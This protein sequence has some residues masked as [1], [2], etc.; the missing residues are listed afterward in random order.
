MNKK[1]GFAITIMVLLI[2]L[3]YSSKAYSQNKAVQESSDGTISVNGNKISAQDYDLTPIPDQYNTGCI[4]ELIE[5]SV[6]GKTVDGIVSYKTT[7]D[8]KLILDLIYGN[9]DLPDNAIIANRDFPLNSYAIYHA[10]KL[11]QS[12]T[13]FF[14][15]CRFQNFQTNGDA[16]NL[17]LVFYNCTFKSF[18]GG[19]ATFYNCYFGGSTTDALR[20][21][22]N[23]SVNNCYI[24]NVCFLNYITANKKPYHTD[25]VQIFGKNGVTVENIHF[26]NCRFEV[27]QLSKE[28]SKG[29]TYVNSCI[30]TAVEY[31]NGRDI[32]YE[33]CRI[34]GGGYSIYATEQAPY[35][36]TDTTFKNISVGCTHVWGDIYYRVG[37]DV[38]FDNVVDTSSL[39][40]G[41][42]WK[43]LDGIHLS[44]TNDTNQVRTLLV[45]TENKTQQISIPACPVHSQFTGETTFESLPFDIDTLI[46]DK[47]SKWVLCYDITGKNCTQIRYVNSL[48]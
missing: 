46:S 3:T 41:S 6:S 22:K 4:S 37:T 34:N 18:D 17:K 30:M 38:T 14:S 5:K 39:Y 10:E 33:D 13:L 12:R 29:N 8:S 40:I 19:G 31:S 15:N 36:L 26:K 24:S 43:S 2:S 45:Y 48:K 27:P 25:G 23:A 32:S 9:A 16:E 7:D 35:T 21:L 20:I 44:V 1:I 47:K 11:T 28:N 42:V